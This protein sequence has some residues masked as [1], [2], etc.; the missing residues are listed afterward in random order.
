MRE[1]PHVTLLYLNYTSGWRLLHLQERLIELRHE[2]VTVRATGVGTFED[3]GRIV[4]IH[5][6]LERNAALVA[7]HERALAL[8]GSLDGFDPG[9]FCEDRFT[10]HLSIFR[11]IAWPA[12]DRTV[13][14]R[15][16]PWN[17]RSITLSDLHVMADPVIE[18]QGP[19]G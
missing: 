16:G 13:L 14:A 12:A 10:P 6:R 18:S 3:D 11:R 5:V 17:G 19:T 15:M 4:N 2:T 9:P 8:V 7:A 1:P